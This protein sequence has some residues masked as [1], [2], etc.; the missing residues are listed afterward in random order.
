[1]DTDEAA[2]L[3]LA[4]T[5]NPETV[6]TDDVKVEAEGVVT[7]GPGTVV[8]TITVFK[9]NQPTGYDDQEFSVKDMAG[10]LKDMTDQWVV[11]Y[12]EF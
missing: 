12:R 2:M 1:M 7:H 4:N 3:I 6:I 11:E 10:W 8:I 5:Q 9:G